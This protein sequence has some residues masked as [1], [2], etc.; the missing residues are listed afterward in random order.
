MATW[1]PAA[2][3]VART[4]S[5]VKLLRSEPGGF[6]F[7]CG[8]MLFRPNKVITAA[9]C[10]GE[11][12][13][14]RVGDLAHVGGL[15]FKQGLSSRIESIVVH[16]D[17]DP[18][19]KRADIAVLTLANPR[20]TAKYDTINVR[21]MGINR[22]S[23]VPAVGTVL[24]FAGWG[25]TSGREGGESVTRLRRA[26][27]TVA[28]WEDCVATGIARRAPLPDGLEAFA[29]CTSGAAEGT[30]ACG[31]DSGGPL[32]Y[33]DRSPTG[34]LVYRVAGIS[35]F[36]L[37]DKEDPKTNTVRDDCP[38]GTLSYFTRVSAFASWID[39]QMD[40]G[41]QGWGKAP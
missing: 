6:R 24:T 1:L 19:T 39:E 13:S 25:Q 36:V 26:N 35:S 8:G 5:M 12:K 22:D 29:L 38:P 33:R 30:S 27:V 20:T 40:P 23:S 15:T 11:E 34:R 7:K 41:W 3:S 14:L 21:K 10:I 9:H 28:A 2:A 16:P 17:W 31:G 4:R 18:V 32:Y 37:G